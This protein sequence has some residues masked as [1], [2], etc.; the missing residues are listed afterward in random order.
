MKF[1]KGILADH[2]IEQA[3]NQGMISAE[4]GLEPLQIQPASVDLRLGAKAYRLRAS[5]LPNGR[6]VDECLTEDV[7]MHT[8]DLSQGAVLETGC[9]YLVPLQEYVKLF[10]GLTA[11][12]N[13]KSSTGRIDVFVRLIA[14][15]VSAFDKIPEG[16]DGPI[17]AEVSPRTFSVLVRPGDRLLQMRF[18]SGSHEPTETLDFSVHLEPLQDGLI[19]YRARRHAHVLD[20]SRVAGHSTEAYWEP[21]YAQNKR[22]ILDPD[23]F[24]ILASKE[25]VT[26]PTDRAAEMAPI[27]PDLGEFR[28]HYAGFFDPGFGCAGGT[29]RAVLEVRGR[30]VP[31]IL[32]HGQPVGRLVYEAMSEEP[33]APYGG[34]GSNYQGQG[35]KLSKHFAP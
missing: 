17:Y 24:Y 16:Y 21:V 11:T 3:I 8:I 32:E 26:I 33:R 30:D 29:G 18:R 1:P 35:L 20:I 14:D 31:F 2:Q 13:P 28:A 19:G 9:V 6:T 23:E 22:L 27:A 25:F 7:V 12:A 5:F 4:N 15:G 10:D 34:Q